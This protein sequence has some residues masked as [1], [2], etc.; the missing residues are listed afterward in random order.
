M[1]VA[2]CQRHHL[3][4]FWMFG[5]A[6]Y[7]IFTICRDE[8][9][10]MTRSQHTWTRG[11]TFSEWMSA[12]EG[13]VQLSLDQPAIQ[14]TRSQSSPTLH[15]SLSSVHTWIWV[16]TRSLRLSGYLFFN[17]VEWKWMRCCRCWAFS[18]FAAAFSP[19]MQLY[20]PH[21]DVSFVPFAVC[22][23]KQTRLF[24]QNRLLQH[25]V[26]QCKHWGHATNG[27]QFFCNW[28]N[29]NEGFKPELQL[30]WS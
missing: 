7:I 30:A 11:N 16:R 23:L 2:W 9:A 25:K 4:V 14:P 27:V 13:P 20:L 19:K 3:D 22:V 10:Q 21:Q 15:L 6:L 17:A 18:P 29:L 24:M 8:T 12:R 28:G 1:S 5:R 26:M